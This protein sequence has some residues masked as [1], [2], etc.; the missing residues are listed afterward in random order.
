MMT[1]S[2]T[3]MSL[4]RFIKGH[5]L[6]YETA[7]KEIRSGHKQSHW[8]WYIFPQIHGL[9]IS[10]TS[11]MYAIQSAN[12]AKEYMSNE[13]LRNHMLEICQAL[14]DLDENDPSEVMGYP[15]DLKLRSSMTLFSEATPEY[16]I[17]DKVLDK[18][19][20]GEKDQRTVEILE[21]EKK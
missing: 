19:Y 6:D 4:E 1:P 11:E 13:L 9:G 21:K 14:L 15:D 20:N 16:D 5:N 7:L 3:K 10:L 17:F 8:I 2:D 12:E 18:Y